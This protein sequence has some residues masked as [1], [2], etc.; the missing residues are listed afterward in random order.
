MR[1]RYN[2][3][4][5]LVTAS[6]NTKSC[7]N[8]QKPGCRQAIL[9]YFLA[10][11][12]CGV[13]AASQIAVVGDRIFTDVMMA[14]LMGAY[15]FWIRDGIVQNNSI[16]SKPIAICSTHLALT[17]TFQATKLENRL[18]KFLYRQGFEAP[19]LPLMLK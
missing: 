12:E 3:R 8:K 18:T 5:V 13:S 9:D 17:V 15:A 11:P 4:L 16:V 19:V 7:F 1:S 10:S 14:N 6:R 2:S